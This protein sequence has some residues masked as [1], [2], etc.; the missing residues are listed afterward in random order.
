M[1][2]LEVKALLVSGLFNP[3]DGWEVS[4]DVDGME[5][6]CGGR[7]PEGKMEATQGA[8]RSLKCMGASIGADEE[9]GRAD[10]VARHPDK[11]TYVIECE[12][13]T[14]RQ[15]EQSMYSALGQILLSMNNESRLVRYAL[16]LPDDPKWEKQVLKIPSR[17]YSALGLEVYMVSRTGVSKLP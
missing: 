8:L 11:G 13:D 3:E 6:A 7:H 9:Y 1:Y 14:S 17:L 5:R 4:V 2:Q 15:R 16:A 12:G 10:I